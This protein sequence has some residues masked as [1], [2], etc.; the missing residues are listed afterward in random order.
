MIGII[1]YGNG[2][3]TSILNSINDLKL[4]VEIINYN[5]KDIDKYS[6]IILPGV[7]SFGQAI[8]NLKKYNL[9]NLIMDK[10]KKG[11]L[12][13]LGIC[14]GMQLLFENSEESEGFNGFGLIKG[15]VKKI[16]QNK[17]YKVPNI[18]WRKIE[19]IDDKDKLFNFKNEN[20]DIFYFAHSFYCDCLNKN[21]VTSKIDYGF[22]I[23][24]SISTYNILGLQFH[25]EK[26]QL[27]GLSLLKNFFKAN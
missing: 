26:S 9:M 15:K 17:L 27:A 18:G 21:L 3:L 1:N 5:F 2:N 10:Y 16:K 4:K 22:S 13:I 20:D 24:A 12:K 23:P 14:L 7:G 6:Y 11:N 25:P 19:I 8:S